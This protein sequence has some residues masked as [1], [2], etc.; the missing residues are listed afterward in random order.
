MIILQYPLHTG[1][2]THLFG[3]MST[4]WKF[5]VA[6]ENEVGCTKF[7]VI[8]VLSGIGASIF[9][10]MNLS[11]DVISMG[12]SGAIFGTMI[13]SMIVQNSKLEGDGNIAF[14]FSLVH[15]GSELVLSYSR[16]THTK[17]DEVFQVILLISI[18]A[19]VETMLY[20]QNSKSD[21]VKWL[22][23]RVIFFSGCALFTDDNTDHWAHFGGGPW[24]R[25]ATCYC[26]TY[27]DEIR[28]MKSI[29]HHK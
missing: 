9:S 18:L 16:L 10:V 26:K 17:I 28:P 12:A 27:V 19:V 2:A 14:S 21:E 15:L 8:Y 23:R 22:F 6:L 20:R 29:S 5:G 7:L 13:A 4:L 24:P 11:P 1:S 3:N 25:L